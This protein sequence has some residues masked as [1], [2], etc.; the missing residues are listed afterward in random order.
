MKKFLI[1]LLLC[2]PQSASADFLWELRVGVKGGFTGSLYDEPEVPA[3]YEVDSAWGDT[4]FYIGGGAGLFVEANFFGFVGLAV[5]FWY[6]NNSY[7]FGLEYPNGTFEYDYITRF[8]QIRIPILVKLTVPMGV[9][10]LNIGIG[11]E[12]VIGTK[13]HVEIDIKSSNPFVDEEASQKTLES[14]Y[15]AETVNATCLDLELG[16]NFKVWKLI[17]PVTFR[18]AFN[19]SQPEDWE[20]RVSYELDQTTLVKAKVK[21]VES[22]QFSLLIGVGYVF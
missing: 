18:A 14:I 7:K 10:E 20:D 8:Q 21:A 16:L 22:Y 4:Q 11:P 19:L 15:D 12:F 1:L 6:Q 13:A 5:E 3:Y 9:A 17:I 2:I